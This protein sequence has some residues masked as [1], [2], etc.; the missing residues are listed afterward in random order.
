MTRCEL[1][2]A[3]TTSW[4]RSGSLRGSN[5]EPY[6]THKNSVR[7]KKKK[8]QGN[9]LCNMIYALSG[10]Y[11]CARYNWITMSWWNQRQSTELS[12]S[13]T[14]LG[15][16]TKMRGKLLGSGVGIKNSYKHRVQSADIDIIFGPMLKNWEVYDVNRG[17]AQAMA[18]SF[19]YWNI[20]LVGDR[21]VL[22]I[23]ICY[24]GE[25]T[26]RVKH[27]PTEQSSSNDSSH[28]LVS[29][30]NKIELHL[31]KKNSV[32][33][34][35][36]INKDFGCQWIW[37]YNDPRWEVISTS[38]SVLGRYYFSPRV[39]IISYPPQPKSIFV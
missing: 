22:H 3:T 20:S 32:W 34:S 11:H 4:R 8:R 5:D 23:M 12:F 21:Q 36:I 16:S 13:W 27:V 37:N 14:E 10:E 31:Q 1:A 2:V 35:N 9:H 25:C 6:V 33:L 17:N 18:Q 30:K 29:V 19:R 39:I 7:K 28:C 38:D 24:G 26:V 15:K